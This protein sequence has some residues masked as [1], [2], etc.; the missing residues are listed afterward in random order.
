MWLS[1]LA[2]GVVAALSVRPSVHIPLRLSHRLRT[3]CGRG[4]SGSGCVDETSLSQRVG[5]FPPD[6]AGSLAAQT[7]HDNGIAVPSNISM[8]ENRKSTELFIQIIR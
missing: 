8:R 7:L 3:I 6:T 5:S 4:Y 1:N 2:G